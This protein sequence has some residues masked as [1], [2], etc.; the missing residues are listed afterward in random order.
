LRSC[1]GHIIPKVL[2]GSDTDRANFISQNR[3]VNS[4]GYNQF[5]KNVNKHLNDLGRIY[6]LDKKTYKEIAKKGCPIGSPPR[7]PVVR[8]RIELK[9]YKKT[10]SNKNF[11]FRPDQ[12]KAK[13]VFSDGKIIEGIFSNA[14]TARSPSGST[15]KIW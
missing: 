7:Y 9:H 12:I 13:A 8:L 4:G 1:A 6:D 14:P 3:S 10:T 11:P 15:W 5:G 2:G